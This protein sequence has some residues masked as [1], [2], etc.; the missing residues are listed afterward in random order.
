MDL[1]LIANIIARAVR[2]QVKVCIEY[3]LK[4]IDPPAL[5]SGM[6]KR[7]GIRSD[8]AIVGFWR[9]LVK[10]LSRCGRVRIYQS[11]YM[12]F[13]LVFIHS[14]EDVY[15]L[16][17]EDAYVDPIDCEH[18]RCVVAPHSHTLRI[19]LEGMYGTRL[20]LKLNLIS[21]LRIVLAREP[22]FVYCLDKYVQS[23]ISSESIVKMAMCIL[24]LAT[25]YRNALVRV[26]DKVPSNIETLAML[27]P[28]LRDAVRRSVYR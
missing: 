21:V 17:D 27:S 14:V 23:P 15:R 12:A 8:H 26:L 28:V 3:D 25:K 18:R 4:C 13:D 22:R 20:D 2:D 19:Y 10:V 11:K 5:T 24:S 1:E 16:V 6:L 7:Y 9:K